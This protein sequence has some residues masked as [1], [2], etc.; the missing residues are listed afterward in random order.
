MM[1]FHV[2]TMFPS[3]RAPGV[4]LVLAVGPNHRVVRW[5]RDC[6]PVALTT[7]ATEPLTAIPRRH[8][9]HGTG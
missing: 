7:H 9:R 6:A 2:V 3:A 8:K 1:R 4:D 5:L